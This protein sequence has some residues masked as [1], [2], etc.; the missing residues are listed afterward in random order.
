M[1]RS[2]RR[3]SRSCNLLR[4]VLV[5]I[6]L[7]LSARQS[8]LA[9]DLSN[10]F[11]IGGGLGGGFGSFQVPPRYCGTDNAPFAD[12]ICGGLG[13]NDGTDACG[14]GQFCCNDNYQTGHAAVCATGMAPACN[15]ETDLCRMFSLIEP[16]KQGS[17]CA[18]NATGTY[19]CEKGVQGKTYSNNVVNLTKFNGNACMEAANICVVGGTNP[20]PTTTP[21]VSPTP[22]ATATGGPTPTMTPTSTTSGSPTATPTATSTASPSPSA[23]P[24]SSVGVCPSNQ[25]ELAVANGSDEPIWVGGGGGALRAVC[26]VNANEQCIPEEGHFTP[27]TCSCF[28]GKTYD[29]GSPACPGSS[30]SNGQNC[31]ITGNQNCGDAS[32]NL[33]TNMCY[34]QLPTAPINFVG[35]TPTSP[36]NWEVPQSGEVDFCLPSSSVSWNG[37]HIES[38]VWWSGGVFARTGCMPDGT[39]CSSA[40]CTTCRPTTPFKCETLPNANCAAGTNGSKPFSIAEFTLQR[41]ANDFYDITIINGANLGEEMAP[42]GP[43]APLPSNPPTN[44]ADYWCKTPGSMT[45]NDDKDCNWDFGQYIKEVPS[46]GSTIDATSLLMFTPHKCEVNFGGPTPDC[47][48]IDYQ[49]GGS[50]PTGGK[51]KNGTCY[52]QCS[53]VSDCPGSLKCLPAANGH[54]YCQCGSDNDCTGL[55]NAGPHCGVQFV[56]GLGLPGQ[57]TY[58]QQCG[59]FFGWWTADDFC[60]SDLN[61][62]GQSS[63]PQ[64]TCNQGIKN[65]DQTPTNFASLIGCKQIGGGSASNGQSCYNPAISSEACCGCATYPTNTLS[66]YWPTDTYPSRGEGS[67]EN[68][69]SSINNN[70]GWVDNIQPWLV[71]LKRACPTGYSFPFDDFTSTFQCH[72]P[73]TNNLL[74]YKITFLPLVSP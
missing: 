45:D 32:A 4:L 67:C 21:S 50:N 71:N 58:L 25:R 5:V 44:F 63:G 72:S 53:S 17:D 41:T 52:K 20:T 3:L 28:N 22:T 9:A 65:G 10:Q 18:T 62:V 11:K 49:C 48:A 36:W 51:A 47:P 8:A 61:A 16:C 38:T 23:S 29:Q 42:I 40:D 55:S 57:E 30:Q 64:I 56:P 69:A 24:T 7:V 15:S 74:G 27:T 59:D 43:T 70:K 39:N 66:M 12:E 14:F 19:C 68:D 54:S 1:V 37:Q 26:V 35:F 33:Q 34:Y 2:N 73:G 31:A 6:L 60:G 46:G 13:P